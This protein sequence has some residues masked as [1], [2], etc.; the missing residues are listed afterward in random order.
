MIIR[1]ILAVLILLLVGT[2]DAKAQ[3]TTQ[4]RTVVYYIHPYYN[5]FI[6]A[7]ME[8]MTQEV[9]EQS[10][11][12][13]IEAGAMGFQS[14]NTELE[15][16]RYFVKRYR[17]G[18]GAHSV[19]LVRLYNFKEIDYKI[20]DKIWPLSVDEVKFKQYIEDEVREFASVKIELPEQKFKP[21][22]W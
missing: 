14:I 19:I 5:S 4:L 15:A 20:L 8:R 1:K 18:A 10:F 17:L 2:Y 11:P 6:S 13:N 7:K 3:E 16:N 12:A 9:V 22:E 21:G